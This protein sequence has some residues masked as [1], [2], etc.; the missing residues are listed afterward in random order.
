MIILSSH[1]VSRLKPPPCLSRWIIAAFLLMTAAC[2]A[3]HPDLSNNSDFR[4]FRDV[5][6]RLRAE[7]QR[8]EGTPHRM[9]GTDRRG[10]DCSGFVM[11]I[12]KDVF[13][14]CLP[15]TAENQM[16]T[17][18]RIQP[19]RLRP[20]DLVFFRISRKT[21][22]V[23]IYLGNSEFAHVSA[24][25]KTGISRLDNKYWRG[26]YHTSRRILPGT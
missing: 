1:T 14:I 11:R 6:E 17:G 22:H 4:S 8:W 9:G 10:A 20:G 13:S 5:G 2:T 25:K 24:I 7:V 15:R 18:N 23:G 21:R 3:S 16:R 12:Y 19:N 26:V